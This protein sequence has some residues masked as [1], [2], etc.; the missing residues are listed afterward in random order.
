MTTSTERYFVPC[1]AQ[2][3]EPL[4]ERIDWKH[5]LVTFFSVQ[6]QFNGFDNAWVQRYIVNHA[7]LVLICRYV[8]CG[9]LDLNFNASSNCPAV[10]LPIV[11][12]GRWPVNAPNMIEALYAT[13][14]RW[15]SSPR[16]YPT[17]RNARAFC[18]SS[19]V[20]MRPVTSLRVFTA[21]GNSRNSLKDS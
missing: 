17:L 19:M 9:P 11:A 5:N 13:S 6:E 4:I 18:T 10:S 16:V 7:D 1:L 21:L 20:T 12:S 2:T 8:Q 3:P 15:S 14:C